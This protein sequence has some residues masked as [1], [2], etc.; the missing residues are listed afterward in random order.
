VK[1]GDAIL[2]GLGWALLGGVTRTVVRRG[3]GASPEASDA[4]GLAVPMLSAVLAGRSLTTASIGSAIGVAASEIG[5]RAGLGSAR[6]I[7]WSDSHGRESPRREIIARMALEPAVDLY[8]F[9]GD[10]EGWER[11]YDETQPLRQRARVIP[12]PGNH[13]TRPPSDVGGVSLPHVL[14]LADANVVLLPD[15]PT[16]RQVS[17]A[18]SKMDRSLKLNL[19]CLHRSPIPFSQQNS[20]GTVLVRN[21]LSPLLELG[22]IVLCGH[23]HVYGWGLLGPSMVISAGIAGSKHYDCLCERPC[24]ECDDEVRGYLRVEMNGK[25]AT[26]LVCVTVEHERT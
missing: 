8:V 26:S 12:L 16:A 14:R 23:H 15:L 13:D 11:W 25:L 9:G 7:F 5:E 3:A 21:V 17:T 22:C 24:Q 18:I 10:A 20:A 2:E 1:L 4:A 6:V 19:V